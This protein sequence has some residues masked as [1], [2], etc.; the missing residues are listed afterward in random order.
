MKTVIAKFL[1]DAR[2]RSASSLTPVVAA[3]MVAGNP[4]SSI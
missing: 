4:W 1:T 2:F 3:A